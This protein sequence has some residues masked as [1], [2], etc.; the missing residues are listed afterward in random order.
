MNETFSD[1]SEYPGLEGTN[2]A[3]TFFHEVANDSRPRATCTSRPWAGAP[4]T[5]KSEFL[6]GASM[7][8]MGGGVY[9]YVLYDLEGVDN[10]ASYFRSL[11]YGTHAIH[12]AEAANWRRDRIYEQLG[13]D[14]FDDI[15]T[16]RRRR[17]P[18]RP[19][20]GSHHL[21]A[22]AGEDRR[23]EGPQ[24]VFDVTIQNH[25]G[26]DT[27]L[28]PAADAVHL[29]S[30]EVENPEVDEFLAAIRRSDEDLRWLV[31]ELN[32]RNEPTI[33]VFFGDHQPGF[34]DWLFE[35]TFGK[36]VEDAGLE[37][38]QARYRTPYFIWANAAARGKYEESLTRIEDADVTSLNYLSTLLLDA[39][40]LPRD[41]RALYR[42]AL[43]QA[44][45][46]VNLNGYRDAEGTWHWFGE[47]VETDAQ[48]KAEDALKSY[49]IVQY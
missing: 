17:H 16:M 44:L 34:A 15:T 10:L 33:V 42:S 23:G 39:T 36:P 13:F 21:R 3:P 26:Y 47:A 41:A 48:Q 49:A 4:A 18:P 5:A 1:L 25:G 27:G 14:A 9:P 2:A 43:R 29:E 46:A 45:P 6:T 24:F 12:P 11:G 28:V 30:D 19:R 40:G 37:E 7:G 8:N 32:A 22:R 38:V 20:H 35:E 31:D